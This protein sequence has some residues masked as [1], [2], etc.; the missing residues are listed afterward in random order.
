MWF[1]GLV[2][3]DLYV[4]NLRQA[5]AA[6][7]DRLG[8]QRPDVGLALAGL[9]SDGVYSV[10]NYGSETAFARLSP[11]TIDFLQLIAI[12]PLANAERQGAGGTPPHNALGTLPRGHPRGG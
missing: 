3:N 6:L 5:L 2:N 12:K 9:Q 4:A 11:W 8:F 10:P 7:V 1:Q